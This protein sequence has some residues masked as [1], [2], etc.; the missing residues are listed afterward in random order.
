VAAGR[1]CERVGRGA[2]AYVMYTSGSTGRPKGV[3]A[4][5]GGLLNL[6]AGLWPLLGAGPAVRGLGLASF[7]FDAAVWEMVIALAGGGTLVVATREERADSRRLARLVRSAGVQAA[8]VVPSLLG[9]LDPGELPGLETVLVG[10][11]RLSEA[12]GRAWSRGRRLVNTYG[13][14][15]ATV[16]VT[17]GL[18]G[19]AGPGTP[20]IGAPVPNVD[21][22]VLDG[23][24]RLVPAGVAGELFV[25][26]VQVARGYAGRAGLTAERF[27]ADPFG[28]GG[29]RLYRT[30]DRVRWRA[31][32]QLEF[33]GRVDDQVK[34]RG[35]R[36]ELGEVEAVL[37]A[38]PGVRAAAVAAAGEGAARRL[39]GYLVAADQDR[40]VPAAGE[41]R[42]YLRSR[43]PAFMIPAAFT[44]LPALP[45]TPAGKPDRNA[46][47][48][49]AAA[50]VSGP[51][52]ARDY[53][54]PATAAEEAVA[55]IWAQVLGVDRVGAEDNFFELGG[56][57]LLALRVIAGVRDEFGSEV[58][59]SALFD[60]PT[61]RG[62]AAVALVASSGTT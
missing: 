1:V 38:C 36:I 58:P 14:T 62:L 30:G 55:G 32:G 40:G 13:P 5:H 16:M 57:S 27:V 39:V 33:L 31:D 17:A 42:D 54:A 10:G 4:C 20:P 37:A 35:F 44:Q 2:L 3:L 47:L 51:E 34:V 53:I 48:A 22:Y 11:E 46:L 6:T 41:L 23:R 7:S 56:H 60:Q 43:L 61:V 8:S 24:L 19:T 12:A 50:V 52:P 21:L 15:E 49:S 29:G 9:V 26:G 18:V 59:V 28:G 25:G 45:L